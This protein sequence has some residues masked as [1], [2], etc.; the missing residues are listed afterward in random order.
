MLLH[1]ASGTLQTFFDNEDFFE[2]L[3]YGILF[4][5]V[6]IAL[7]IVNRLMRDSIGSRVR[8]RSLEFGMTIQ[9]L[10]RMREAG[11]ISEEEYKEIKSSLSRRYMEI[12]KEAEEKRRKS[13]NAEV[14]LQAEEAKFLKE[15]APP[16]VEPEEPELSSEPSK[17]YTQESSGA[18]VPE[19]LEPFMG[20]GDVELD[21]LNAAGF[22]SDEDYYEVKRLREEL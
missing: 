17:V 1:I 18:K 5:F 3:V 16:K 9:D 7:F 8:N 2:M 22:I 21:E 19:R 10:D 15:G 6:I 20:M 4:V 11:E 14:A 13:M 12:A